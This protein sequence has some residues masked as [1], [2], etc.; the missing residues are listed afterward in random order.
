MEFIFLKLW[1]QAIRRV[2]CVKS[3]ATLPAGVAQ[4]IECLPAKQKV[5]SSIPSQGACWGCGPGPQSGAC[6]RQPTDRCISCTSM[7][8]SFSFSLI[9]KIKITL[10]K[11]GG[12]FGRS[13]WEIL[14]RWLLGW[15]LCHQENSYL[16]VP[17]RSRLQVSLL[18]RVCRL[19]FW[20]RWS[21]H[22]PVKSDIISSDWP[23]LTGRGRVGAPRIAQRAIKMKMKAAVRRQGGEGSIENQ[24]D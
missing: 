24:R 11:K 14:K 22:P 20:T 9:K 2:K 19:Y 16:S 5:A 17:E 4:Q 18:C 10:E 6:K 3:G 8:L 12:Y 23:G 15:I 21:L 13:R 7:F 1:D